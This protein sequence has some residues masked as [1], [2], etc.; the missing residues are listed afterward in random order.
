MRANTNIR[1]NKRFNNWISQYYIV[2]GAQSWCRTAYWCS[3]GRFE[4]RKWTNLFKI[5]LWS[6][7][8]ENYSIETARQTDLLHNFKWYHHNAV[9]RVW[10]ANVIGHKKKLILQKLRQNFFILLSISSVLFPYFD[11]KRY[12]KSRILYHILFYLSNNCSRLFLPLK[13]CM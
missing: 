12:D 3:F 10:Q 7:N 8:F 1:T 11:F 4:T 13:W 2:G 9:P 6:N 5:S